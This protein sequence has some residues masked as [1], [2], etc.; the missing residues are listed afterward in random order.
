MLPKGART[1]YLPFD[2][3][4]FTSQL[5]RPFLG[6]FRGCQRL[7]KDSLKH[8]PAYPSHTHAVNAHSD[9]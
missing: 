8:R 1:A 5:G 7:A 9:D 6:L 4:D 3:A 2:R